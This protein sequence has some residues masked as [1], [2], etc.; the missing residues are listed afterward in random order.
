MESETDVRLIAC[1]ELMNHKGTLV[2][3]ASSI[4]QLLTPLSVRV[5]ETLHPMRGRIDSAAVE[6]VTRVN[7]DLL[8]WHKDWRSIHVKKLGPS[9][10]LLDM[11]DAELYYAQLWCACVALRGCHWEKLTPDQRELAFKAKDAALK[12]LGTYKSPPLR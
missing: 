3:G 9:H 12:C 4:I 7:N 10:V 1:V 2:I 5:W 6:F 11:L 8:L